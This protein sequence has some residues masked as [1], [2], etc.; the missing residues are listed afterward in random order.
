[1]FVERLNVIMKERGVTRTK[2]LTDLKMGKN[3][4]KFWETGGKPTA[5]TISAIATYFNVSP[6]YLT[7][8]GA[9][10]EQTD[11]IIKAS[12]EN[13]AE[14]TEQEK[15]LLAMFRSTSEEGRL[16]IIQ[17]VM[18][19]HDEIEKKIATSSENVVG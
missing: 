10:T 14:V 13:I 7:G 19:I 17:A 15:T 6:E 4:F 16:R 2:L 18:N 9:L 12:D 1:M 3:Q 5:A 11:L 8:N